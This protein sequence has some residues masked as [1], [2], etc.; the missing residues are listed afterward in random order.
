[1]SSVILQERENRAIVT[2][3]MS[4][5]ILS[6]QAYDQGCGDPPALPRGGISADM[7]EGF[8]TSEPS[9]TMRVRKQYFSAP[10]RAIG[11][12]SG[13]VKGKA[14]HGIRPVI[15]R[16]TGENMGVVVLDA[17]QRDAGREF[18]GDFCGSVTG[19]E[20]TYNQIRLCLK[21]GLKATDCLPECL[22]AADICKIS[23]IR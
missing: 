22:R 3:S 12:V 23:N 10:D 1:M 5:V 15:F 2:G 19:V 9:E 20:I 17:H 14:E 21:Q 4:P 13:T 18:S 11:S 16:H 8:H 7:Q 6:E